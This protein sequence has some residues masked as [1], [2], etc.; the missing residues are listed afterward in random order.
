MGPVVSIEETEL[1]NP[2]PKV[3]SLSQNWPNPTTGL[4]TIRYG[5]PKEVSP[6]D[7]Y[8]DI[9]IYDISGRVVRRLVNGFQ[10]AGYYTINWDG[11]DDEGKSLPSGM[12]FYHLESDGYTAARVLVLMR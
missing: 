12:Y 3:F 4:T 1:F 9:R 5:L 6:Q 7:S 11:K 2:I 10:P 8:V